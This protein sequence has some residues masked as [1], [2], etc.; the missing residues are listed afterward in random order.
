MCRSRDVLPERL[1][2]PS[3]PESR[4]EKPNTQ[5]S[6]ASYLQLLRNKYPSPIDLFLTAKHQ[7]WTM[8]VVLADVLKGIGIRSPSH[9][10]GLGRPGL[11]IR[12]WIVNRCD[13]FQSV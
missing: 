13:V 9:R 6:N 12:A 7:L 2:T 11:C 8:I 1:R 4:G 10:K 3:A 5:I